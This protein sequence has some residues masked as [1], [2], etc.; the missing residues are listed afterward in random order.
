MVLI[1][2]PAEHCTHK[3]T[4][5]PWLSRN[6]KL[7]GRLLLYR[8]CWTVRAAVAARLLLEFIGIVGFHCPAQHLQYIH[9]PKAELIVNCAAF[10]LTSRVTNKY[11]TR[12]GTITDARAAGDPV[13]GFLYKSSCRK[14]VKR[15]L[16]KGD[17]HTLMQAPP[18]TVTR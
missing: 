7:E 14:Y 10:F 9:I 1:G 15:D 8:Y 18:V 12:E 16:W 13:Q 3:H 6:R 2:F 11:H 17:S 4:N 5:A